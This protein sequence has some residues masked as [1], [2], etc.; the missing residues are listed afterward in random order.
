MNWNH[1]HK[2]C[3]TWELERDLQKT[4]RKPSVNA[5]WQATK[6]IYSFK[7]KKKKRKIT[8]KN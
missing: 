2:Q 8:H 1:M 5:S 4:S 7:R 3:L 6:A